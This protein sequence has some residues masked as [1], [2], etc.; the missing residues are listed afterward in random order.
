MSLDRMTTTINDAAK[1][2]GVRYMDSSTTSIFL[3][4]CDTYSGRA[5]SKFTELDGASEVTLVG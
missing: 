4:L 1:V 3:S 2:E 5:P